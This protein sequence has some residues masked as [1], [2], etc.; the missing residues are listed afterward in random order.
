M[1]GIMMTAVRTARMTAGVIK[2]VA[3]E[4]ATVVVGMGDIPITLVR[5]TATLIIEDAHPA[6]AGD[7][8]GVLHTLATAVISQARAVAALIHDLWMHITL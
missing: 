6:A 7:V 8:E 1:S 3:M 5:S 4:M 2:T